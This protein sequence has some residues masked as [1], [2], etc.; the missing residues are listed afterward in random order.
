[1]RIP[2]YLLRLIGFTSLLGAIPVLI[3]GLLAY[4]L[5]ADQLEAKALQT[6]LQRLEQT[7]G[8]LENLLA[9]LDFGVIQFAES[10]Y[11]T[12]RMRAPLTEEDYE[13]YQVLSKMLSKLGSG[14]TSVRTLYLVNLDYD[15]M[16][17]QTRLERFSQSAGKER[18]LDY[19]ALPDSSAWL[20]VPGPSGTPGKSLLLVRKLPLVSTS[21]RPAGL[22][23]AEIDLNAIVRQ[24][25][26]KGVFYAQQIV[27]S[28]SGPL[29]AEVSRDQVAS[30]FEGKPFL[31]QLA[32]RDE[33]S[34]TLRAEGTSGTEIAY[35]RSPYTGWYYVASITG[36]DKWNEAGRIGWPMLLAC[37]GLLAIVALFVWLGSRSMYRPVK[38]LY[39]ALERT[40]GAK[41]ETGAGPERM[42]D[43]FVRM[44]RSVVR[45]LNAES[46]MRR[47]VAAALPQMK[48]LFAWKLFSGQRTAVETD[49][50][51]Q[52]LG[53]PS[54][55]TSLSVLALQ[56]DFPERS[57]DS[58]VSG[59]EE[60]DRDFVMVALHHIVEEVVP[61]GGFLSPVQLGR[62]LGVLLLNPSLDEAAWD[63]ELEAACE[64]VRSAAA[65]RLGIGVCIGISE[66]FMAM[67]DTAKAYAEA[68]DALK[69]RIPN[70]PGAIY[71]YR[72]AGWQ[73][74]TREVEYPLHLERQL[75]EAVR[76]ARSQWADDWLSAVFRYFVDHRAG[77]E[78][79]R[80]MTLRLLNSVVALVEDKPAF[81][82]RLFG[83]RAAAERLTEAGP[84]EE[85]ERWFREEVLHPVIALLAERVGDQHDSIAQAVVQLIHER[86]ESDLTLEAC[87]AEL[88]FHPNHV[89][90]V[91]KKEM[92]VTFSDYLA[93]Y[94][95]S[96]SKQWLKETDMK[97]AD[98][99]ARLN[100]NSPAAFIR[101]FRNM[102]GMTPGDYR[103]AYGTAAAKRSGTDKPLM[104]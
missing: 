5:S 87:A 61:S 54:R 65:D 84:L 37:L 76:L 60:L 80:Y 34:G 85:K 55:W 36:R 72:D 58:T 102:E 67:D 8:E 100:Y 17:D 20:T 86:A 53:I 48:E 16:I 83:E 43:E 94:R 9:K 97:I 23:V 3:L 12:E 4:R 79:C 52:L 30:P 29:Y 57:E 39:E 2:K 68:L 25:D 93:Q 10:P 82:I 69:Y 71:R 15:W 27:D 19:A 40:P 70:G 91:F 38:K 45:L 32:S 50:E 7:K 99:S 78:Q 28:L 89:S 75:L 64:A 35:V 98:I 41:P 11:V 81:V 66:P 101:Y 46:A 88:H 104:T 63:N 90:R 103:K 92:G 22:L 77:S 1:M 18:F 62:S 24:L 21:Q 33:V 95:L 47:Q 59:Y 13:A 49:E 73:P 26:G 14:N 31:R 42:R 74:E 6:N 96:L 51:R 44:E 56:F